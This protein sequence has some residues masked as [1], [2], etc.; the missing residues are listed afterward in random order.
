MAIEVRTFVDTD[1]L[2]DVA[3]KLPRAVDFWRRYEARSKMTCSIISLFELLA[4]CRNL[5][6]QRQRLEALRQWTSSKSRAAIQS[7]PLDGTDPIIFHAALV[8]SIALSPR[9]LAA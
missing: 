4:G 6:E 1:V 3:R 9:L 7:R 8:F 5:Q 2:I